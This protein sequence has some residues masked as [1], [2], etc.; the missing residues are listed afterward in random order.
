MPTLNINGK[1]VKVDDSFL[2]LSPEEQ[3]ATVDEIAASIGSPAESAPVEPDVSMLESFGRGAGQGASLGFSD[4]LS[5]LGAASGLPETSGPFSAIARPAIGFVRSSISDQGAADYEAALAERRAELDAAQQANPGTFMAG[6]IVGGVA[7]APVLPGGAARA[8]TVA[9]RAGKAALT[10]AGYGAAYGAGTGETAEERVSGAISGG[11]VGAGTAGVASPVIDAAV[12]GGRAVKRA[13]VDPILAARNPEAEAA[14]RVTQALE[15]DGGP[16][17]PARAADVLESAQQG[18]VPLIVADTGGETTRALARSAANN[19]PEARAALQNATQDRFGEQADRFNTIVKDITGATGDTAALAER[20]EN[21]GRT[22][23]R[24]AYNKA[25]KEGDVGAWDGDLE[26]LVQAPAVQDAIRASSRTGA[27]KSVAEGSMPVKN[28]FR[29]DGETMVLRPDATPTLRFWDSVKR[30]MDDAI[31]REKRAGNLEAAKDINDLRKILVEKMDGMF[32]SYR[33]ARRGAA[34]F[35]DAEDALEAGQKIVN[36]NLENA[37]LR[38]G[39]AAMSGPEKELAKQGFANEIM[40]KASAMGDSRNLAG[41]NFLKSPQARERAEIVLGKPGARR[42]EAFVEVENLMNTTKAAVQGNSTTARQLAE[43]G[44]ASAGG[45]IG[46]MQGGDWTSA[47]MGALLGV[48]LRRGHGMIEGKVANNI[49]RMLA[50]NDPE[51]VRKAAQMI[52]RN[53]RYLE[54]VRSA[55]AYLGRALAPVTGDSGVSLPA[56]VGGRAE[57]EQQPVGGM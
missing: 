23:N 18:D 16:G 30:N 37:E 3:D 13:V 46:A 34:A 20:V 40:R 2:S 4:E 28:A 32:P 33:D 52:A 22:V 21:V 24:A 45:G 48:A 11:L 50:S 57:D 54:A 14:R 1:R 42:L 53:P 19:S 5:A 6:E 8:A 43:L 56:M 31:S 15:I 10:G 36:S 7:T 55:Q 25:F 44:L 26:A 51:V 29:F 49:G 41:A 12:A 9:G 17:A 35:F 27:N 38:R 39:F 47:G